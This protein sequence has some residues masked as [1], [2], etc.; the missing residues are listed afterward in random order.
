[1]SPIDV[2][3]PPRVFYGWW[4]ALAFVIIVFLTTGVRF[5]VG[6]FLKPIVSDLGL[7]RGSF[8]LVISLSLFLY[9]AFMPLVGSLVDRMGARLVCAGGGVLL[10]ASLALTARMTSYWEFLLYFGV[11]SSLGLAATG[12]VVASAIL[13]RWFERRRG[14]AMSLLGAAGMAGMSILVP[15]VMWCILAFGW[16]D[17][18]LIMAAATLA[19]V[20]PL[21][22]L[23]LRDRP[24]DL[25]LHPD[26]AAVPL[27][28]TAP[29]LDRTTIAVAL[30]VPAF[31]QLA[32]GLACCGFSMSLISSH[33]VPMLTDHG[34]HPMT[35]SSAI[36]LLGLVSM[37][38]AMGL[39]FL[40]DRVGR[41]PVLVAVYV[42]RTAAFA[43]LFFAVDPAVL[44]VVAAFGGI[45]MSG[46][47]A[48]VSALTAD[49]F[50]R[51]SVG[52]IFGTMFLAHQVGAALGTWL[53][54]ALF[55]V[56]GGYGAAFA[57]TGALLLFAA[58]L[59]MAVRQG[60]HGSSRAGARIT[61]RP[62]P[63]PVASGR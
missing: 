59:S 54:G 60:R 33:A 11:L 23:V 29:A 44:M 17:S 55:D 42:L 32:G 56:T 31:W 43:L 4:V 1:M 47:L 8:S 12:H 22:L 18:L 15:V 7:D 40:S 10:A 24:E 37:G 38:G 27:V 58:G 19:L 3:R 25:G 51:F 46:S 30:R 57:T 9:G 49:I 20:L 53:G 62:E 36:G 21:A 63:H 2:A 50:G 35:A 28:S 48:M 52:S 6:P 34:F 14:T 61:P 16:R 5:T 45:G 26:G 39:G 13:T 41:K